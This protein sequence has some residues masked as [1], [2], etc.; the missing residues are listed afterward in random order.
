MICD[1]HIGFVTECE[2]SIA[3]TMWCMNEKVVVD[4]ST[5]N[6]PLERGYFLTYNPQN[7]QF[8]AANKKFETNVNGNKLEVRMCFYIATYGHVN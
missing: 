5:L 6:C 4:V 3:K 7:G 8:Q 1:K 2:N